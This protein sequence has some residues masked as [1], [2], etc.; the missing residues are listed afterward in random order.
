MSSCKDCIHFV[1]CVKFWHS[2]YDCFDNIEK[3]KEKHANDKACV[4]FKR[5]IDIA[6]E[7][8]AEIEKTAKDAIRF[9]ERDSI[10][11]MLREA[12]VNCYKDLLGYIA[13]LKSRYSEGVE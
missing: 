10:I 3:S 12:K 4:H 1:A 11:P 9:C 8:F 13:K 2:D 6:E 7:I 5:T